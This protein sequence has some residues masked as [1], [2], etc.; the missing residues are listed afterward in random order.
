MA[1]KKNYIKPKRAANML[2]T[3]LI[4]LILNS[5]FLFNFDSPDDIIEIYNFKGQDYS[6][7]APVSLSDD[8]TKIHSAPGALPT[9]WPA[10]LANGYYLNGTLGKNSG[11]LSMT[12]EDFN[13]NDT[14]I[15]IDS[16][17]KLVIERDPYLEFYRGKKDN[18]WVEEGGY[19]GIDTAA[20]NDLIIS[21]KLEKYFDKLK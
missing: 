6:N 21:G 15:V 3:V 16:L 4:S 11:Y 2:L 5:C 1:T 19:Y 10:K 12:I 8:K 13:K 7:Y 18:F 17:N 14:K 20:I 9:Q